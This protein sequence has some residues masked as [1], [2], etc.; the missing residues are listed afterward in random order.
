MTMHGCAGKFEE[1]VKSLRS[2]DLNTIGRQHFSARTRTRCQSEPS[3]VLDNPEPEVRKY[4]IFLTKRNGL[5]LVF[6]LTDAKFSSMAAGRKNS[7]QQLGAEPEIQV[8]QGIRKPV[9]ARSVQ[10]F[11]Q[12]WG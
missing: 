4:L 3:V 5:H 10:N 11:G 7:A 8:T 1:P 12:Q 9:V 2:G 6:W